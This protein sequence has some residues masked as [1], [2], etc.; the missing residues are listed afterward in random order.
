LHLPD[1]DRKTTS[2]DKLVTVCKVWKWKKEKSDI[3]RLFSGK[4]GL[5]LEDLCL[6]FSLFKLLRRRFEQYPMVEVGS[7]MA[8]RL[9]L[10]GLFSL[11]QGAGTANRPFRV[12]HLELDF[13]QHYYQAADR[14]VMSPRLLFIPN[15][16]VSTLFV[17][18]YLL[19]ILAIPILV[20]T[21]DADYFYCMAVVSGGG[22]LKTFPFLCFFM[23][24][25]LLATL[26]CFEAYEFF[27]C[28][29]D[30]NWNLVRLV[31]FYSTLHA[32]HHSWLS[33][34]LLGLVP[35]R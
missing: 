33:R 21:K 34:K 22:R 7:G 32:H 24:L 9:M 17:P 29:L 16:I 4:R 23:T 2:N 20:T 28:Y 19:A 13:L 35:H 12:L 27:T 25:A 14:T 15:L 8:R 30:F 18:I 26:I 31:C 3:G 5:Y 6:S 10:E 11:Q 1:K